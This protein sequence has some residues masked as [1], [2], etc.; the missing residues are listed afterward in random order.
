MEIFQILI[1]NPL[2]LTLIQPPHFLYTDT[3][4]HTKDQ[5][6]F[7]VQYRPRGRFT[8]RANMQGLQSEPTCQMLE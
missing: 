7:G 2:Q 4:S 3:H 5:E 1:Q 6:P 8:H